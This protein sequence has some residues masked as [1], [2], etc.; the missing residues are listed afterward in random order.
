MDLLELDFEVASQW[1]RPR[2]STTESPND[3][4]PASSLVPVAQDHPVRWVEVRER[5][6]AV[7]RCPHA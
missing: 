7:D 5:Q 4:G 6:S 2:V 3:P 1:I